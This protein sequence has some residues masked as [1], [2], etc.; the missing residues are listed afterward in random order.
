MRWA[1][2][3]LLLM[4]MM[5]GD[6]KRRFVTPVRG[7]ITSKFGDR[8]SP[9]TGQPTFHNGVDIAVPFGTPIVS[10][11]MGTVLRVY[12]TN[13]GGLQTIIEHPDGYRSGYAHLSKVYFGP[14][15][16]VPQGKLIAESGDSGQV[17]GPHLHFSWKL[18]DV[19]RDPELDFQFE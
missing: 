5:G 10:P 16:T 13:R 18:N 7:R 4:M 14:G 6:K 1:L 12:R 8:I 9:T 3:G 19:Y 17:T 11:D 15:V 2:L